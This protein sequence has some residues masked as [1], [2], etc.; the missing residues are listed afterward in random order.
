MKRILLDIDGCITDG[1]G[2]PIDLPALQAPKEAI[3][4]AD[5]ATGLCTGRSALYVEAI[6]QILDLSGW[7]ICE[8]GAYLYHSGSEEMVYHPAINQATLAHLASIR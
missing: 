2:Q 6:A 5:C 4:D 8:N 3:A 1:K 7:C